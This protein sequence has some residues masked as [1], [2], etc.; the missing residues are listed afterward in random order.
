MRRVH[1]AVSQRSLGSTLLVFARRQLGI[2]YDPTMNPRAG[3]PF[4]TG[5]IILHNALYEIACV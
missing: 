1:N 4:Q 5:V 3:H 2:T